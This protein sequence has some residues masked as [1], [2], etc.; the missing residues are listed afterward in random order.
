M[1]ED[2]VTTMKKLAWCWAATPAFKFGSGR[3]GF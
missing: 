3:P 2:G 1:G